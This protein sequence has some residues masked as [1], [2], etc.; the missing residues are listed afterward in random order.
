MTRQ[1]ARQSALRSRAVAQSR[2]GSAAGDPGCPNHAAAQQS[3]Y[4]R[5]PLKP[6]GALVLREV[7]IQTGDSAGRKGLN[8]GEWRR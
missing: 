2:G 4:E 5:D 7:R 3:R 6:S 1:T 8:N